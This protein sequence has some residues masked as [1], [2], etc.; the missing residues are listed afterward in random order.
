LVDTC[1]TEVR[2]IQCDTRVTVDEEVEDMET[3]MRRPMAFSGG[4][5]TVFDLIPERLENEGE[6]VNLV[7][8]LT[9]GEPVRWPPIEAWPCPVVVV[10][11]RTMPPESYHQ[12]VKLDLEELGL[13]G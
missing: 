5:G 3:L 11:T 9:D 4:G 12:V 1:D 6:P 10:T 13:R 2:L 8:L 7:V